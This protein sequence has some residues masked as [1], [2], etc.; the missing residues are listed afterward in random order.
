[1]RREGFPEPDHIWPEY[2]T[3]LTERRDLGNW[4]IYLEDSVVT[5]AAHAPDAAVEL[6]NLLVSRAPVHSVDVLSE[7][8]EVADRLLHFRNRP[9]GRV[10]L[11]LLHLD[12]AKLIPLPDQPWILSETLN[13]CKLPVVVFLPYPAR[14][15][16]GRYAALS[17]Y[18]GS[19]QD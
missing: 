8:A 14:S 9:M 4:V 12:L 18:P 17:R 15:S 5:N 1:M 6:N 2:A 16:E 3:A 7:Y 13:G 10:R 11:R 19:C